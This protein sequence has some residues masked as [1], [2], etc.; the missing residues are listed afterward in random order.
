MHAASS[1]VPLV[2]KERENIL[3]PTC[4]RC[5]GLLVGERCTDIGESLGG[6]WFWAMRCIQC[7]D[8]IDDII[9]RNRQQSEESLSEV[10]GAA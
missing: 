3:V 2:A 1:S 10:V 9:L 8:L 5:G 7:G 6:S 4:G